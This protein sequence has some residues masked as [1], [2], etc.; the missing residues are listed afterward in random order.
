MVGLRTAADEGGSGNVIR[1]EQHANPYVHVA[2][3][4]PLRQ[5]FEE[6]DALRHQSPGLYGQFALQRFFEAF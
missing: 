1:T 4:A 3:P 6:R 5:E 2:V